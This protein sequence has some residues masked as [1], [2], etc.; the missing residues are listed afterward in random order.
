[1]VEYKYFIK[2]LTGLHQVWQDVTH[3][4]V[5]G[6]ELKLRKGFSSLSSAVD[7]G[8]VSVELHMASL[9]DA[10]L[11]HVGRR[12]V[13]ITANGSPI[14]EGVS[15]DDSKVSLKERSDYVF[16]TLKFKPYSAFFETAIAPADIAL[17][18]KKICD[19]TDK[20]NSLLHILF[21]L[22]VENVDPEVQ[23]ILEDVFQLETAIVNTKVLRLFLIEE[24]ENLEDYL[25]EFLY[26]SGYAYYMDLHTVKV[27]TPYGG[28]PSTSVSIKDIIASPRISQA[29]YIDEHKVVVRLGKIITADDEVV[30]ELNPARDEETGEPTETAYL[31]PA[32]FY[33]LDIDDEPSILEADYGNEKESDDVEL[34]Y[35]ENVSLSYDARQIDPSDPS[36]TIP[37]SLLV[38]EETLKPTSAELQFKNALFVDVSLRNV[39]VT[40]GRAYYRDWSEEHEDASSKAREIETIDGLYLPD[41]FSAKAFIDRY[42]AEEEA[43]RTKITF[44]THL[45]FEP[46][47]VLEFSDIPYPL[48]V[49][50]VTQLDETYFEYE[51]VAHLIP[52]ST[53]KTRVRVAPKRIPRDGVIG[54]EGVPG[55]PGEDATSVQIFSTNG[56][57]FR[58]GT[59]Y[60]TMRAIVFRGDQD[61]TD[62][63]DESL[64]NW[65]RVSGDSVA[66][67]SWNTSSKAVGRKT[68]EITPSD[69]LGRT[70]F[71]CHVDI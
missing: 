61:I 71:A 28:Y 11:L 47:A 70:V 67:E 48:L 69:V 39:V 36:K 55:P 38:T 10:V 22:I 51:C 46:G 30:Y 68:V 35:A 37:A 20:A 64:F 23:P 21:D 12:Q 60:T 63:I 18:D 52:S 3:A 14:F 43:E 29:P 26:H 8:S 56:N 16:A 24:G 2:P 13:L 34:A 49:R 50:Y 19:P 62:E 59:A 6:K 5:K 1:M 44:K 7:M 17:V 58:D 25:T 33:P 9:E 54:P 42:V 31:P 41:S 65:E 45:A 27:I 15:Y 66:D 32:S 57:I 40:A 53:I 4:V